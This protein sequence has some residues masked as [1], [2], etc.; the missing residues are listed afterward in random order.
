MFYT[1]YTCP[2]APFPSK[3]SF[4]KFDKPIVTASLIAILFIFEFII[5]ARLAGLKFYVPEDEIDVYFS[6][7][8]LMS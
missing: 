3:E 6:F 8:L 1:K 7:S 4:L 5:I 2:N